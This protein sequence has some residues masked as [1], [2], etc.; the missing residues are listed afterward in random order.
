M[1]RRTSLPSSQWNADYIKQGNKFCP[2]PEWQV[3][4]SLM[5]MLEAPVA[6][7][8][9]DVQDGLMTERDAESAKE[10]AKVTSKIGILSMLPLY[11]RVQLC[12]TMNLSKY[13]SDASPLFTQHEYSSLYFI[14]LVGSIEC[15]GLIHQG[16]EHETRWSRRVA[17]GKDLW[18]ELGLGGDHGC[19]CSG[20]PQPIRTGSVPAT[21]E[22]AKRMM[23][24]V[25]GFCFV[26]S[27]SMSELLRQINVDPFYLKAIQLGL[28]EMDVFAHWD[29]RDLQ[30]LS[31]QFR[32]QKFQRE[33]VI[34]CRGSK[35]RRF[36]VVIRGKVELSWPRA[37]ALTYGRFHLEQ[38]IKQVVSSGSPDSCFGEES[39]LS[40]ASSGCEYDA[41]VITNYGCELLWAEASEVKELLAGETLLNLAVLYKARKESLSSGQ[42]TVMAEMTC[43]AASEESKSPVRGREKKGYFLKFDPK[44]VDP[45]TPERGLSR[46][47]ADFSSPSDTV[48]DLKPRSHGLSLTQRQSGAKS[49]GEEM[50][51]SSTKRIL[52]TSFASEEGED[53]SAGRG[54]G[55]DSLP[56][57]IDLDRIYRNRETN[58]H[59][60]IEVKESRLTLYYALN[61]K[62]VSQMLRTLEK[63]RNIERDYNRKVLAPSAPR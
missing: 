46:S 38:A 54:E 20:Y 33:E 32:R 18:A 22:I 29:E 17:A 58:M 48:R 61:K 34:V 7:N 21:T 16:T 13:R 35:S 39:I 4:E 53:E 62:F 59:M 44:P 45:E 31:F 52:F 50:L 51:R 49:T 11:S 6:R 43:A 10:L 55:G 30:T 42:A 28:Q 1:S 8:R 14:C 9:K 3:V 37:E 25:S 41:R 15:V 26:L 12:K 60:P 57:L 5:K 2:V 47:L 56:A 23:K 36:Y 24:R 27:I 40:A 63:K 19:V